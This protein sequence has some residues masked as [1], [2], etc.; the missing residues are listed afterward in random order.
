MCIK[1]LC[2]FILFW[3]AV[4]IAIGLYIQ[5]SFW[6]IVLIIIMLISGYNLFC[7]GR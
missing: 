4:G 5:S 7:G 2:G 3:L 1:K 6:I